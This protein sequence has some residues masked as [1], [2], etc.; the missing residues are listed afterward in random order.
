MIL[1]CAQSANGSAANRRNW[2]I[3]QSRKVVARKDGDDTLFVFKSMTMSL[4]GFTTLDSPR[5]SSTPVSR[6]HMRSQESILTRRILTRPSGEWMLFVSRSGYGFKTGLATYTLNINRN[7]AQRWNGF[8]F[9]RDSWKRYISDHVELIYVFSGVQARS[10]VEIESSLGQR[11][12]CIN[13]VFT[14]ATYRSMRSYLRQ[15]KRLSSTA[16]QWQTFVC[17]KSPNSAACYSPG[18]NRWKLLTCFGWCH[19]GIYIRPHSTS[20]L[21]WRCGQ[22]PR[23]KMPETAVS[24]AYLED[25][26]RY[27]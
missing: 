3:M 2:Y 4:I 25:E 12:F 23:P 13:Y 11:N 19:L 24:R 22:L 10:L 21:Y 20:K 27:L 6:P 16:A 17:S 9:L 14:Y 5:M 7:Y 8:F 1:T 18:Y 26:N 15:L